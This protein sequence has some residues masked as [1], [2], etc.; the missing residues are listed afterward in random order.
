[1]QP[2]QCHPLGGIIFILLM[3][4]DDSKNQQHG[5][6]T[7]AIFIVLSSLKPF[8]G[9]TRVHMFA[10]IISACLLLLHRRMSAAADACSNRLQPSPQSSP[11]SLNGCSVGVR[12]FAI[13][14][15]NEYHCPSVSNLEL[16]ST[17]VP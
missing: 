11:P 15:Y 5:S 7:V 8:Q 12:F 9:E 2:S 1:M 17:F 4:V 16:A 14:H 10:G 13:G 3:P 6:L